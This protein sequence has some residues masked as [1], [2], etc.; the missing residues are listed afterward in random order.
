MIFL[1][2]E[3][4]GSLAQ[5]ASSCNLTFQLEIRCSNQPNQAVPRR[6]SH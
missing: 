5:V 6:V 2:V 3:M 4:P 1:R